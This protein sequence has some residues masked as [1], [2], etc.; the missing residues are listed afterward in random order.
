MARLER[1]LHHREDYTDSNSVS[2]T[3]LTKKTKKMDRYQ[4]VEKYIKIRDDKKEVLEKAREEKNKAYNKSLTKFNKI[5]NRENT[6]NTGGP[7]NGLLNK[8]SIVN[9]YQYGSEK[10]EKPENEKITD[11]DILELCGEI[12]DIENEIKKIKE[13]TQKYRAENVADSLKEFLK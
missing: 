7:I 10:P 13:E 2:T 3:N 4:L 5:I 1:R 12:R 6:V 11:E 9:D 8:I